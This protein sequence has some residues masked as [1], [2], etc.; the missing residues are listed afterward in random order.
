MTMLVETLLE[1]AI[2]MLWS[3][4]LNTILA[5]FVTTADMV[6]TTVYQDYIPQKG[7]LPWK[8]MSRV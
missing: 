5:W 6:L 3:G 4:F 2:C 8:Q 7:R 1:Y